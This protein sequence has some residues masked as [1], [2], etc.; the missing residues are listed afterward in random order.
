MNFWTYEMYDRQTGALL[1]SD[2]GFETESDA[3]LQANMDAKADNVKNYYIRT[4]QEWV[5]IK[6]EAP[7]L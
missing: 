1:K 4:K 6:E 2:T 5:E 3:E 7:C